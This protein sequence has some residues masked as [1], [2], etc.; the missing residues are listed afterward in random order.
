MY[1]ELIID[2]GFLKLKTWL[3]K[4]I[5]LSKLT[6]AYYKKSINLVIGLSNFSSYLYELSYFYI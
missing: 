4:P 5:K 3:N 2:Y 6:L 1:I